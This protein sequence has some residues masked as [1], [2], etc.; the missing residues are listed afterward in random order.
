M[1]NYI[2]MDDVGEEKANRKVK[3]S[4]F[5]DLFKDKKYALELYR[6]LHPED[7][8]I[9]EGDISIVTIKS[10]LM[11]G[12]YNDLGLSVRDKLL[13]LAEAQS[14]WSENILVRMLM[15]AARTYHNYFKSKGI[16]LYK[17]TKV[18]LPKPEFYVVYHNDRGDKPDIL[19]LREVFFN[20]EEAVIDVRVKV[21]Y[22]SGKNDIIDQY[23]MF[24]RIVDAQIALYGRNRV[25]IENAIRI[26][27]SKDI[28]AEYLRIRESE[29]IGIMEE[30]FDEKEILKTYITDIGNQREAKGKVEGKAEGKAEGIEETFLANLANL[31]NFGYPLEDAMDILKVP[32]ADRPKY[33]NALGKN[34]SSSPLLSAQ[35]F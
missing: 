23:I 2:N 25:A 18:K 27:R 33:R 11:E 30:L 10:I 8:S 5:T 26:C 17:S 16:T 35:K 24:C 1:N 4:V 3:D 21:I 6:T 13:I 15:Y 28:L 22:G 31:M 12:I 14:T 9:N 20:G 29:V 32:E 19:S 7:T 34:Q